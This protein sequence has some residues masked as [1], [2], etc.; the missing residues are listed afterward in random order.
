[1]GLPPT[2]TKISTDV[3]PVTTFFF[4]FP[5]F[6][7]THTGATLSLGVNSPAG[8]G[9]GLSTFVAGDILYATSPTT[10]ARLP[11]GST[12]NALTVSGS[13]LPAWATLSP[14]FSGLSPN[15]PVI[16]AT[17]STITTTTTGTTGQVFTSAGS[18]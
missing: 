5:N 10:L 4:Q 16:A 1:M 2:S 13:N 11:I 15:A 18:S 6:T 3:N 8:G 7:G 9:T 12:G 17:S 14:S